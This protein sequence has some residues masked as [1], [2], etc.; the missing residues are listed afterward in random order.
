MFALEV[1]KWSD[2]AYFL[3]LEALGFLDAEMIG[4]VRERNQE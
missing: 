1:E 3:K 2:S 4:G